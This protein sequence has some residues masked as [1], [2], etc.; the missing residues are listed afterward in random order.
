MPIIYTSLSIFDSSAEILVN[1]VNCVGVMGAGLA[2]EYKLRYPEMFNHYARSCRSG[3]LRI[4]SL[5]VW[6][7]EHT[8]KIIVNLPTKHDWRQDS[9]IEIVEHG[10]NALLNSPLLKRHTISL[11][12][13]GCGLGGLSWQDVQPVLD[14]KMGQWPKQVYVH[15]FAI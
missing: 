8:G 4:G 9:T 11:P 14:E 15:K 10:L 7:D 3:R 1:P 5:H 2:K 12:A 6:E 13:L